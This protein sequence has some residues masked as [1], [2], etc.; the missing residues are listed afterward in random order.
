VTG[1]EPNFQTEEAI[2]RAK[3]LGT[4]NKIDRRAQYDGPERARPEALLD[5][6]NK[7][8]NALRALQAE[9]ERMQEQIQALRNLRNSIFVSLLTATATLVADRVVERF[10]R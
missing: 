5:S 3:R 8:W 7:Q 4:F 6:H 10:L 2:E 9:K 1:P